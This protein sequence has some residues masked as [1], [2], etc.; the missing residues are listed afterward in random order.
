MRSCRADTTLHRV[1]FRI[2]FGKGGVL[3]FLNPPVNLKSDNRHFFMFSVFIF[4]KSSFYDLFRF[5]LKNSTGVFSF[6]YTK[7]SKNPLLRHFSAKFKN[8]RHALI[9]AHIFLPGKK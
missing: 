3:P 6:L 2:F 7:N 8:I 4:L 1:G 9:M 5:Y